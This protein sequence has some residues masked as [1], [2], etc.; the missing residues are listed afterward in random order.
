M[1]KAFPVLLVI[2]IGCMMLGFIPHPNR[3]FI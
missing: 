2:R 3:T 1:V